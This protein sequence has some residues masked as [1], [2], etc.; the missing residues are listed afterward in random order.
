[1]GK[2]G[3]KVGVGDLVEVVTQRDDGTDRRQALLGVAVHL[4]VLVDQRLQQRV[5]VAA[6]RALLKQDLPQR[7]LF[8][9]TH[10]GFGAA[11]RVGVA[12]L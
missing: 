10:T 2:A 5:R 12:T 6:Q 3:M 8:W 1:V 7:V 4:E 11:Q 9:K